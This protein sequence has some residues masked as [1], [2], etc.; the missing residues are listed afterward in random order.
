MYSSLVNEFNRYSKE[1]DLDIELEMNLFS[2]QNV[3]FNVD[4]Y[5]SLIDALLFK[6]SDKYDVYCFDPV[7]TIK[8][9]PFLLDLKNELPKEHMDLY[10][11]GDG[12][13]VGV[14]NDKW[15]GLVRLKY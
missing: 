6:K 14:Y 15:V 2:D 4:E 8:Y 7:Y 3:T 9:A 13:K 10:I 12:E 1:N 5:G 11:S